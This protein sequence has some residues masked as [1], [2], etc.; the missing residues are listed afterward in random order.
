MTQPT[1][2]VAL[3]TGGGSGIGR[4]T[5]RLFARQGARVAVVDLALGR[6]QETSDAI[7]QSGGDSIAIQADVSR[8][9]AVADM[10]QQVVDQWGRIDVLHNNA[11]ISMSRTLVEDVDAATFDQIMA[12]NVRGAFLG[13]KHVVSHMKRQRNG[14]I[15]TTASTA[16]IR[17]REGASVYSASKGA[18]IALT[19]ALAV[20]LAPFGIRTACVAPFATDTPMLRDQT[21]LEDEV[22]QQASQALIEMIPLGRLI[23]PEDVAQAVLY[24]ASDAAAM[25]TGTTL[26][27]DGGRLLR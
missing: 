8:E 22:P 15:I 4:A 19:K 7:Q 18:V 25:I 23:T 2:K 1:G 14:V 26:E 17:P 21:D 3:V 20:E 16:G 11:G 12:V 13:A 24:L 10:V 5:A 27:V 6:A 9:E